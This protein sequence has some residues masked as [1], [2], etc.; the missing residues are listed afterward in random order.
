MCVQV[1]YDLPATFFLSTGYIGTPKVF[2]FDWVVYMLSQSSN[3]TLYSDLFDQPIKLNGNVLER[4]SAAH[5]ILARLKI[6]PDDER[7]L[8]IQEIEDALEIVQP[9]DGFLQSHAMTWSQ[10]SEM[11]ANGIELGSLTVNHPILANMDEHSMYLELLQSKEQIEQ[12]TGQAVNVV[13][14]P[15]GGKKA[16]NEKV[17]SA[18][19]KAGYTLACSYI[20]GTNMCTSLDHYE[21]KRLHVERYVNRPMFESMIAVPELF[22][23]A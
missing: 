3:V 9:P 16:F 12:N 15:V 20:P 13:A 1:K 18:V 6:L 14:Y 23:R 8:R 4:R 5:R 22:G 11:A 2:W 21:L 17:K 19:R 7:R 10:V